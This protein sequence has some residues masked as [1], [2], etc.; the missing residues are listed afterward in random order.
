MGAGASMG[1]STDRRTTAT[2]EEARPMFA[3]N[4]ST[5]QL[6]DSIHAER[7]SHAALLQQVKRDRTDDSII[8]NRQVQRRIT[9]RRLAATIAG[10]V[11]TFVIAAAATA[12][13]PAAAPASGHSSGGGVTLIR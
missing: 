4:A 8:V 2:T 3:P 7:L 11:L 10:A 1:G 9:S 6:V 13:Q 12:N 5:H